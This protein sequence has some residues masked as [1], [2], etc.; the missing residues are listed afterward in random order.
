MK[1]TFKLIAVSAVV[2]LG[3]A[4]AK[5]DGPSEV[6]S[7]KGALV[8]TA[9]VDVDPAS[10]VNIA[11]SGDVYKMTWDATGETAKLAESLLTNWSLQ[12]YDS[13]SATV[14]GNSIVFGFD[15]L[16]EPA[17]P[18]NT[19]YDI[20][21]PG[22]AVLYGSA[23][24]LTMDLTEFQTPRATSPD[25]AAALLAGRIPG[26][27]DVQPEKLNAT[28]K[29]ISA[30]GKMNLQG[31]SSSE[32][33]VSIAITAEDCN[34][35]GN[36]EYNTYNGQVRNWN[37]TEESTITLA[38]DNLSA[39]P[40]GFE[41]WFA[42]KPF[43]LAAGKKFTIVTTTSA[44]T[45][46]AVLTAASD[47]VF[48]SGKVT[49]LPGFGDTFTVTFN[50]QGGSA[51]EPMLVVA[52]R[53]FNPPADPS[54]TG[55]LDEG[56]Y[57]GDIADAEEGAS[58]E[59]WYTDS[60]C[61]Q[62]YNFST[63]V[64]GNLTLYA[65]W[66]TR[67]PID[68][69]GIEPDESVWNAANQYPYFGITYVNNQSLSSETHYTIIMGSDCKIW[70]GGL[71]LNN[72][73]A[74]VRLIGKSEERAIYRENCS[75][76]I[77]ITAGRFI[78][79]KNLRV[80][81]TDNGASWGTSPLIHVDGGNGAFV[82]DEG[83]RLDGS[84]ARHQLIRTSAAGAKIIMEGGSIS[85]N[86]NTAD[87]NDFI[88][89]ADGSS[90]TMNGGT[91]SG[92][93]LKGRMLVPKPGE[94]SVINGGSIV[95]NSFARDYLI[96]VQ[97]S[98]ANF[99]M[100]GGS[101]NGNTGTVAKHGAVIGCNWGIFTMAG[102]EI[103]NNSVSTSAL[104]GNIGG[105]VFYGST[106]SNSEHR[107]DKTGGVISGNSAVRNASGSITGRRGQQVIFAGQ[108]K[109]IDADIDASTNVSSANSGSAPWID[110]PT[111]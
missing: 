76:F 84:V 14:S 95:N 7:S 75:T 104:D 52:G 110:A 69:S 47:L 78:L 40:N 19:S 96:T 24:V 64:K 109:K 25:P 106:Y 79:G 41:V 31:I 27:F 23:R 8:V 26:E 88:N 39:N 2:L 103:K 48:E 36:L 68:I 63:P 57:L 35:A 108:S 11:P 71:N 20:L 34:I 17:S 98:T 45:H 37:T 82:I 65:K 61:T 80:Y 12:L 111:E 51:V 81:Y 29:H 55:A 72:P 60:G 44:K 53:G 100:K 9:S 102:G 3:A 85:D 86:S 90:F 21:Y 107:F 87:N 49:T 59:G 99:I 92:N 74:V 28:F 50:S 70:G 101:I 105:A 33:V 66:G 62:P 4:C 46:T 43:T 89:L 77:T 97:S 91:I 1:T 6:V 73:N 93:T 54:K 30:Y 67:Q 15:P 16:V 5:I 18:Q 42:C 56:L 22:S 58:F 94:A 38:G 83:G 32:S 13:N 10:K